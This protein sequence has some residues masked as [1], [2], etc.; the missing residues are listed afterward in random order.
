MNSKG[1]DCVVKS[2]YHVHVKVKLPKWIYD[3]ISTMG[4]GGPVKQLDNCVFDMTLNLQQ[5]IST[6][7]FSVDHLEWMDNENST[8]SLYINFISCCF[9]RRSRAPSNRIRISSDAT[10]L[11]LSWTAI[12]RNFMPFARKTSF[13]FSLCFY[14]AI[15]RYLQNG[16]GWE[17]FYYLCVHSHKVSES[18]IFCCL[19][20]VQ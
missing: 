18:I 11:V 19:I 4:S 3:N 10:S 8:E 1:I 16:I 5:S 12:V 6:H 17:I 7:K 15:K 13:M 14:I 9:C 20:F 2:E